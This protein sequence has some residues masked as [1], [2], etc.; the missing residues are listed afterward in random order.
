MHENQVQHC[1]SISG[2]RLSA[3]GGRRHS[4]RVTAHFGAFT[5]RYCKAGHLALAFFK[6]RTF[7]TTF[8]L[9]F[10]G[11]FWEKGRALKTCLATLPGPVGG[12]CSKMKVIPQCS[13][14]FQVERIPLVA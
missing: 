4:K 1:G 5:N 9:K 3:K 13:A 11:L 10:S 6:T 7:L 14:S 12:T 2:F 8:T